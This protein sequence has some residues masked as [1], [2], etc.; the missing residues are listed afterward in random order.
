ML[1]RNASYAEYPMFTESASSL[2]LTRGLLSLRVSEDKSADI[3]GQA[4]QR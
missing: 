3:E 4:K 1:T 2:I